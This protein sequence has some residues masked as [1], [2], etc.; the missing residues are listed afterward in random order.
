M[1]GVGE[2]VNLCSF[3]RGQ[4]SSTTH[5]WVDDDE[6]AMHGGGIGPIEEPT[7]VEV[8][9]FVPVSFSGCMKCCAPLFFRAK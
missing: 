4:L 6:F 8:G 5:F 7:G 3:I 2:G 9:I 1:A